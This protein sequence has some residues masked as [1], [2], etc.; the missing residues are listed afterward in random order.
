MSMIKKNSL[1]SLFKFEWYF[2]K[3]LFGIYDIITN[4]GKMEWQIKNYIGKDD[5][6]DNYYISAFISILLL[7]HVTICCRFV[8]I[9]VTLMEVDISAMDLDIMLGFFVAVSETDFEIKQ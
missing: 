2:R 8:L 7:L 5:L 1:S 6:E 3:N 4:R 9:V